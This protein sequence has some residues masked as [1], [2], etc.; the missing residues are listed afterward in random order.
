MIGFRTSVKAIYDLV[1]THLAH[2]Y[3]AGLSLIEKKH[4]IPSFLCVQSGSG[5][6]KQ[7]IKLNILSIV[8]NVNT[9]PETP[10]KTQ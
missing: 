5:T 7:E 6:L 1:V 4:Q 9:P 2:R 3:L 10:L 8:S